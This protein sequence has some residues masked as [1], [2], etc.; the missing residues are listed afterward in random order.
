MALSPPRAS[1]HGVEP[2]PS[3]RKAI[4]NDAQVTIPC[5]IPYPATR[6]FLLA[7]PFVLLPFGGQLTLISS[8][9]T[10]RSRLKKRFG[11]ETLESAVGQHHWGT[12]LKIRFNRR[13]LILE[14]VG[15]FSAKEPLI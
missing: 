9:N 12:R 13:S 6:Q 1:E 11:F 15:L 8:V 5:G 3:I 14:T 4:V 7:D 2:A 10:R